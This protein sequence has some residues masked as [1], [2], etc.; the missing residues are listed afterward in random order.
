MKPLHLFAIAIFAPILLVLFLLGPIYAAMLGAAYI[1]YAPASGP[2]PLADRLFDVFYIP[3]VYSQLLDYWL[4]HPT[5]LDFVHYTLPIVGL[6]LLG[7]IV[8]LFLTWK[9]IS[10]LRNAFH[11]ATPH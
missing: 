2:H 1:I 11:L 6:P 5:S 4:K 10:A 8:A 9:L 7:V 3:D